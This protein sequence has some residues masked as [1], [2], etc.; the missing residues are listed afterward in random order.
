MPCLWILI[1]LYFFNQN[2]INTA[3]NISS[4]RVETVA[5][6]C[7]CG[8]SDAGLQMGVCKTGFNLILFINHCVYYLYYL[9]YY[10]CC[11]FVSYDLSFR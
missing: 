2:V 8:A 3:Q 7:T 6:T 10:Y 11:C 4:G 5:G 9:L 1:T